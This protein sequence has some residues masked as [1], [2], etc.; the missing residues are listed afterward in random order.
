M[1][2]NEIAR[3]LK[4]PSYLAFLHGLCGII[5]VDLI[6][7]T[8][9]VNNH[10]SSKDSTKFVLT[11]MPKMEVYVSL[12]ESFQTPYGRALKPRQQRKVSALLPLSFGTIAKRVN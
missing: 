12:K 4:V 7:H 9:L 10:L 11:A 8:T 6:E 3:S 5:F 1:Q 2:V